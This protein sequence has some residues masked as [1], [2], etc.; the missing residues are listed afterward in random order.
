[1]ARK[2]SPDDF[3]E[4]GNWNVAQNYA[5]SIIMKPLY[6][7]EEYI[8]VC[9]FG[10][11]ELTNQLMLDDETLSKARITAL[12][13][14]QKSIEMIIRNTLFAVRKKDQ[15][16]MKDYLKYVIQVEKMIPK[17]QKNIKVSSGAGFIIQ[18]KIEEKVF[19]SLLDILI[20]IS[21]EIRVPLNK[22]DLIFQS[23]DEFDPDKI[24]ADFFNEIANEP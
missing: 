4:S 16:E 15:E 9:H 6:E 5:Q 12:R 13:R 19:N 7:I 17:C 11:T 2:Y 3:I 8:K 14:L 20:N 1:M 24:K 23:V 10:A 22:A 21:Q 18:T